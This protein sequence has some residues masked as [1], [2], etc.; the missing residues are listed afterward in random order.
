M[1]S[2]PSRILSIATAVH[3]DFYFKVPLRKVFAVEEVQILPGV[4]AQLHAI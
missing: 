4:L 1:Q 2:L 3:Q